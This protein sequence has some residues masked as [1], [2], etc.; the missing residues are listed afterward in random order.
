MFY[1]HK[2]EIVPAEG[3]AQVPVPAAAGHALQAQRHRD[4]GYMCLYMRVI[5]YLSIAGS[6]P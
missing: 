3:I 6:M 2:N 5:I 4:I 1:H